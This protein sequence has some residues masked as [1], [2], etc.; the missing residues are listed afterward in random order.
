M[1][2]DDPHGEHLDQQLRGLPVRLPGL[3]LDARVLR[4]ARGVLTPA[5]VEKTVGQGL[6]GLLQTAWERAVAPALVVGTVASYLL[7]ALQ[8]AGSLYQ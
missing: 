8:A 2:T 7:W 3:D 1:M 5:R 6:L 4:Q